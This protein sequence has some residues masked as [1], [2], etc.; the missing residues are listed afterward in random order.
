[1][2]AT[3]AGGPLDLVR[4]SVD[5]W[6][7]RPGDLAELRERVRDLA[8][9]DAKR[10]AFGVRAREAVQGRGWD[11]LG[12][13]L[14][15]HYEDVIAHRAPPPRRP[16]ATTVDRASAASVDAPLRWRRY[17]AVGDSLTEGLC[18]T[19]RMPAGQ[20]RG[21]ADRL[22]LL[23]AL[24]APVDASIAYANLA[25]RSRRVADAVEE[26]LPTAV[27]LGADLVSV[28]IGANDLVGRRADAAALATRLGEAVLEVRGTGAD[29]LL[30]A[31]FMPRRPAA[32]LLHARFAGFADRLA[33][34][35]D[36]SG[37]RLLDVRADRGLVE[38][39][40][41]AA[42]RVHLNSAGHRALAYAA[43]GVLGVPHAAELE[44]LERAIHDDGAAPDRAVG[45]AEW[46]A[47]HAA[48][49]VLRRLRGRTAGDG[50]EA[51]RPAL[52][53]VRPSSTAPSR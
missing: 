26:Q 6:L 7:Y 14:I 28:L 44:R 10:R 33:E 49:W 31:P 12:D 20:Y 47:R 2:V 43:A 4:S 22:A 13:E 29:V 32:R 11:V 53:P 5:G 48:P 51:K 18:D 30:V 1:V 38:P 46:L 15:G 36:G 21:W 50:R 45:D 17:V 16:A 27:S 35:V 37:V 39:D 8:G 34:V 40:R 41:W 9:D 23:L 3:G 52:A 24:A 19:S 25:V 42:D